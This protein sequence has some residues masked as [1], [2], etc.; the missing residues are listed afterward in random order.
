MVGDFVYLQAFTRRPLNLAVR[1]ASRRL[2][3]K[4]HFFFSR[5]L[6]L[7]VAID[8]L[9]FDWYAGVLAGRSSRKVAKPQRIEPTALRLGVFACS[10]LSASAV[11]VR[12]Q[13]GG[14][15][16]GSGPKG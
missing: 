8:L 9:R 5:L 14:V 10:S 11:D 7:F 13:L 6:V 1:A 12:S 4:T 15:A 2:T 3:A 16:W